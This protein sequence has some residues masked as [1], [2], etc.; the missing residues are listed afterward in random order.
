VTRSIALDS[1]ASGRPSLIKVDTIKSMRGNGDG[2][3]KNGSLSAAVNEGDRKGSESFS[4]K[5]TVGNGCE[6]RRSSE[7]FGWK[8]EGY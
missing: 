6:G 5:G 8:A 7:V 3:G 1:V 4:V 2:N